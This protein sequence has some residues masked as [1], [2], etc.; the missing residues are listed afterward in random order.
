M[1]GQCTPFLPVLPVG[2][3]LLLNILFGLSS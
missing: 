2:A 1:L 3:E